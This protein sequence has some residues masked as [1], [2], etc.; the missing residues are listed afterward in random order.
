VSAS[1]DSNAH[2]SAAADKTAGAAHGSSSAAQV[3]AARKRDALRNIGKPPFGFSEKT[4]G[5]GGLFPV[6]KENF[7]E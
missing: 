2:A 5:N 6:R 7:A 4:T 1:D 3:A